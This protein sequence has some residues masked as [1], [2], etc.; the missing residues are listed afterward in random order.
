[1]EAITLKLICPSSK[2]RDSLSQISEQTGLSIRLNQG[3]HSASYRT[4]P[5]VRKHRLPYEAL[6]Q[7]SQETG[8]ELD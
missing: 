8:A 4:P 5:Y 6:E 3:Y 1:M 2:S 7:I